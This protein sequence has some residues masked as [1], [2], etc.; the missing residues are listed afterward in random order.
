M[1]RYIPLICL[2]IVGFPWG[3]VQSTRVPPP[4]A[5]RAPRQQPSA[6]NTSTARTIRL[7]QSVNGTPLNLTIFGDGSPAVFIFGGI[8]GDEPNAAVVARELIRC[9]RND[10]SLYA[11]RTVGIMPA[12]NPD[13]LAMGRRT[14]AHQVDLNRNFPARNWRKS[15]NRRLSHGTRPVSEPETRAIMKA[16]RLLRPTCVISIHAISGQQQCNNYDGP[17]RELA[18]LAS[19]FNGYPSQASIGYPTPGSF[20]S[21]AGVDRR[22]PTITLELPKGQS[23]AQSWQDNRAALLAIIRATGTG[24]RRAQ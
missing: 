9:L 20:G 2:F 17:A 22:I 21:W 13:G 12:A 14:N 5:R 23:G 16:M 19:R 18:V 4:V 11:G 7:G 3:C 15:S 8:H 24:A 6:R 1:R 10:P